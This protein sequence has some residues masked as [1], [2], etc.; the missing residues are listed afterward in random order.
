MKD[1]EEDEKVEI[2]GGIYLIFDEDIFDIDDEVNIDDE[3]G[4]IDEEDE[5]GFDFDFDGD[6]DLDE[7]VGRMCVKGMVVD[8]ELLRDVKV[9]DD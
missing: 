6:Y 5:F 9:K 3:F 1:I 2:E 8:D 7:F 4:G